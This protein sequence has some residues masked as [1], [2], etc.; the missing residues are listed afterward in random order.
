MGYGLVWG[1]IATRTLG[2]LNERSGILRFGIPADV[3]L[4]EQPLPFTSVYWIVQ[5]IAIWCQRASLHSKFRIRRCAKGDLVNALDFGMMT[6]LWVVTKAWPHWRPNPMSRLNVAGSAGLG[7]ACDSTIGT[8]SR[9]G[10]PPEP[11]QRVVRCRLIPF[12]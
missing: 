11:M 9:R 4:L 8:L 7:T 6:L 3:L 5:E 2:F 10:C 1:T 12:L